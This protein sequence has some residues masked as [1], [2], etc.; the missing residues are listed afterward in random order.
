[1]YKYVNTVR[2]DVHFL[3]AFFPFGVVCK[4]TIYKTG[5]K[6][7]RGKRMPNF[8]DI[9]MINLN[10]AIVLNRIPANLM[11]RE[12]E[13]RRNSGGK[14][15]YNWMS[16]PHSEKARAVHEKINKFRFFSHWRKE[17]GGG[18]SWGWDMPKE[19]GSNWFLDDVQMWC[20]LRKWIVW[21]RMYVCI[22][23][24]LCKC[25]DSWNQFNIRLICWSC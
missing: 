19:K 5:L 2:N 22:R 9:S 6:K 4:I 11:M 20:M 21:V 7:G 13:R 3:V 14:T 12:A 8:Q 24:N 1:M 18:W 17:G 15:L 25:G 23:T 10:Y 16:P